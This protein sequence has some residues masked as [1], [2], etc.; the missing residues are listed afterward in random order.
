MKSARLGYFLF[1]YH[2][3]TEPTSPAM[4]SLKQCLHYDPDSPQCLKMHRLVKAFDKSFKALDKALQ[5]DD[6]RGVLKLL[7]GTSTDASDGFAAK[8][9]AALAEHVT[10]E[11][12]E[13]HAQMHMPDPLRT[14]PRRAVILKALCRAH[15]KTG[16]VKKGER[17]CGAL[18]GMEGWE[19]DADGAVGMAEALFKREEWEEAVRVLERAFEAGGRQDREVRVHCYSLAPSWGPPLHA[20]S[21]M[22]GTYALGQIHQR[23][24]KAQ[25]LLKQSKQKDYYKVLGVARDADTRTIKKA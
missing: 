1:P 7:L 5:S 12:M 6:W 23:L 10:R 17:W 8:Y 4:A 25:K 15:V 18:L 9:D 11:T 16:Q 13:L 3:P 2:S 19:D 14:S 20:W 22:W 24:V 21:L